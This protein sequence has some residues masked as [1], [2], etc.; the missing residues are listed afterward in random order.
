M[1][2]VLRIGI[3]DLD[4]SNP[5]DRAGHSRY[6]FRRRDPMAHGQ[7]FGE[8]YNMG[9]LASVTKKMWRKWERNGKK[10]FL[11]KTY[12]RSG[13]FFSNKVTVQYWYFDG[14]GRR[15]NFTVSVLNHLSRQTT[16]NAPI[17]TLVPGQ[18]SIGS[19]WVPKMWRNGTKA[20]L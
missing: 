11:R 6:F 16:C 17:G 5:I 3:K 1:H 18:N 14:E 13:R 7:N 12:V 2:K 4:P 19:A 15:R 20:Q 9:T 10:I 8:F